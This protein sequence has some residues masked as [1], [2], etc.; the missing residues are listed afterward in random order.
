MQTMFKKLRLIFLPFL[1]LT[2]CFV[3]LY[4]FINWLLII[5]L[6]VFNIKE[7]IINFWLPFGLPWIPILIWLRPRIKLLNLKGGNDNLPFLFMFVAAFAMAIPTIIAQKY[8]D[9]ATGKLTQIKNISEINGQPPTK[10]YQFKEYYIDKNFIGV[11]PSF[12][13]SGKHNEYFNMHIY[14]VLPILSNESDTITSECLAWMGTEYSKQVSNRLSDDEKDKEYRKFASLSQEDFDKKNFNQFNYLSRIGNNEDKEGFIEAIKK[15]PKYRL[16]EENIFLSINEPFE[17]RN[18]N[19]LA[20]IFGSFGIAG[21]IWL[22]MIVIAKPN[23][24]EIKHFTS[25][26]TIKS[27]EGKEFL[28]LIKPKEGFFITPIII[29]LNIL[30]FLIMVLSGLGLVSFKGQDLLKWGANFRPL[31]EGGQWWRLFTSMFLHGG[32]FHLF[33]NLY[34]L[35]FVGIFLEPLLGKSKYAVVYILTGILASCTS[36]W[37]HD[38]TISVGASGAIFGLYGLFLALMTT[39][40]YPPDFNKAFLLSTLVFVGF[41]LVMGL[42]GGIDNAAHIGGLISGFII[43]LGLSPFLKRQAVDKLN[44]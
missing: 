6:N 5:K 1:I 39:K 21:A 36:I 14:V 31:V 13:V 23:E 3:A 33:A 35:L 43:G 19:R 10:Y 40:V 12:D 30:V 42:S 22:I 44:E 17:Q 15:C 4:T 41:N 2:I 28:D 37:W 34:G 38:A 11:Y 24:T 27:H 32:L 8:I 7:D 18:G 20:W 26:K 25:G 29:Y 16:K 9:T